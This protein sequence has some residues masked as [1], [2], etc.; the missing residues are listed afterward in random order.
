MAL[1]MGVRA[2]RIGHR[3]RWS[4]RRSG[5]TIIGMNI[6]GHLHHPAPALHPARYMQPWATLAT[7]AGAL[8]LPAIMGLKLD[9]VPE[10]PAKIS[11]GASNPVF[12]GAALA[13]IPQAGP[14][15]RPAAP[16][17]VRMT[18]LLWPMTRT[19]KLPRRTN[20]CR[21]GEGRVPPRSTSPST[22]RSS[23]P[24]NAPSATTSWSDSSP[25]VSDRHRPPDSLARVAPKLVAP[26]GRPAL[27]GRGAVITTSSRA[28]TG[29]RR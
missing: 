10:L 20:A 6:A 4:G 16:F 9:A 28:R 19:S 5:T 1:R 11:L 7:F 8:V 12:F 29:S 24:K 14:G 23:S 15:P 17:R 26:L 25:R 18:G 3:A 2:R 21:P 13:A 27:A 22:S